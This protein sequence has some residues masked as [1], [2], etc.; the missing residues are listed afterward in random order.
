MTILNLLKS[1]I[2][3]LIKFKDNKHYLIRKFCIFIHKY[4]KPICLQTH[5]HQLLSEQCFSTKG[6]WK[7]TVQY[8]NYVQNKLFRCFNMFIHRDHFLSQMTIQYVQARMR[9]SVKSKIMCI[10]EIQCTYKQYK[11]S[12]VCNGGILNR[13]LRYFTHN[14]SS[15]FGDNE[16]DRWMQKGSIC[17]F[18]Q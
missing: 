17:I 14:K 6:S 5:K 1:S 12:N 10:I 15:H 9:M 18:I 16:M 8:G 11:Y 4:F 13:K 2:N 3:K 7:T